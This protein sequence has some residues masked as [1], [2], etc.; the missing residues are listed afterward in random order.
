[1]SYKMA[2]L[3][4]PKDVIFDSTSF[5]RPKQ[6][7]KASAHILSIDGDNDSSET[8]SS[9]TSLIVCDTHVDGWF[10]RSISTPKEL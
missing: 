4:L 10:L 7:C 2:N 9:K 8:I 5:V 1:M 3:G 6:Q